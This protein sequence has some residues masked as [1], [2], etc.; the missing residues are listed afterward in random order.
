M[1]HLVLIGLLAMLTAMSCGKRTVKVDRVMKKIIDT[2]SA[3]IKV[4]LREELDSLCT[5]RQDSMVAAAVDSIL[6][7]RQAEI[8]KIAKDED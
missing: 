7:V 1:R 3:P 6:A 4:L 2:T 5:V 8:Q